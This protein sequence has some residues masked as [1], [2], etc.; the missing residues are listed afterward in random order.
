[1]SLDNLPIQIYC[2]DT[3][4]TIAALTERT[5]QVAQR[6]ERVNTKIKP[7]GFFGGVIIGG[8]KRETGKRQIGKGCRPRWALRQIGKG[9]AER[10]E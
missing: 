4:E 8:E 1:M 2:E 9:A 6:N 5:I 7:K 3:D 10:R